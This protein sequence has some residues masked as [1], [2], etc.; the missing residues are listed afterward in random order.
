MTNR[1]AQAQAIW[2]ILVDHCRA[3]DTEQQRDSFIHHFVDRRAASSLH[4]DE[5]RFGGSLGSGGKFYE[6]D[7]RWW[8]AC[9]P[10]DTTPER[11]AVITKVNALLMHL[12]LILH[13]ADDP[14]IDRL[15]DFVMNG[16]GAEI[17]PPGI[18]LEQAWA[19]LDAALSEPLDGDDAP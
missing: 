10:E 18:T 13:A 16:P 6:D 17:L 1:T 5:F 3:R 15:T 14:A 12:R 4:L 2:A 8:I 19:D 9:Y 11:E 7:D